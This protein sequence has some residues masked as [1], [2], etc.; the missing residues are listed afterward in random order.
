[1]F[2][3]I[4]DFF[5]GGARADV[6]RMIDAAKAPEVG[7]R[8]VE[9][10]PWF[11][12]IHNYVGLAEAL[13]LARLRDVM[14]A[15]FEVAAEEIERGGGTLDKFVGD[16]VIGMFGAPVAQPDHAAQA[17]LAALRTQARV[18][19]LRERLRA[20]GWPERV[21]PLRVRIG[22]HSGGALVGNMGTATRFNYTMMGDNVNLAARMESGA[23]S[24]GVGSLCT[25]TTQRA[26]ELQV[27]GRI[28]FRSLG[29][30]VV[31]GRAS[32]GA[33]R[34]GGVAQRNDGPSPRMRQRLRVRPR[35]LAGEGLAGR[36]CVFREERAARGESAGNVTGHW[37]QPVAAVR[38]DGAVVSGQSG[39]GA[40][41]NLT[42][43]RS[44]GATARRGQPQR[45]G[46]SLAQRGTRAAQGFVTCHQFRFSG[47]DGGAGDWDM[48]L[49]GAMSGTAEFFK[50]GDYR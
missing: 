38:G 46:T 48:R 23:K 8:E 13:P 4:R 47:A 12:S 11:A 18:G 10:T 35:A 22:L 21:R 33:F 3:R 9:L 1:M 19:E 39:D 50:A 37:H 44:C 28:V 15:W 14:N 36:D 42:R 25:E 16:A 27:P 41:G 6:A 30:I 5:A 24:W 40:D 49:R 43:L 7:A 17:C 31:K 45:S 26:C 2:Q 34:T 29:R 20:E 32:A